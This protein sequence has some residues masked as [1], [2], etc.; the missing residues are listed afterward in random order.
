MEAALRPVVREL[1]AQSTGVVGSIFDV[2]AL[3][4]EGEAA[5]SL[6]LQRCDYFFDRIRPGLKTK[7][8]ANSV[9]VRWG[10]LPSDL[11]AEVALPRKPIL[12]VNVDLKGAPVEEVATIILG[13]SAHLVDQFHMTAAQRNAIVAAFGGGKWFSGAA[14]EDQIGESFMGGFIYAFSDFKPLKDDHIDIFTHQPT[15]AIGKEIRR[16]LHST[17]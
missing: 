1:Y 12:T 13:E 10:K 15:P 16:I 9:P 7:G 14:Y 11:N 8:G 17:R 2:S 5:V 6:A 4:R 3:D